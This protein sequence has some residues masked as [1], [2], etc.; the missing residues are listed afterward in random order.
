MGVSITC[1]KQAQGKQACKALILHL[2]QSR[3]L[4]SCPSDR[5]LPLREAL[6]E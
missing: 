2:K 6:Q 3:S 4:T 1:G 5:S